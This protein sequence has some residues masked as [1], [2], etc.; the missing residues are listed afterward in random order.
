MHLLKQFV[1][2]AVVALVALLAPAGEPAVT[3]V[4]V[5][6]GLTSPVAAAVPPGDTRRLFIA[7]KTDGSFSVAGTAKVKVLDIVTGTVTDY[8]TVPAVDSTNGEEGVLGI[9]FHP[10]FASNGYFYLNVSTNIGGVNYNQIRR[11]TAT[12]TP[13][14]STSANPGTG[15]VILQFDSLEENHNGGFIGFGAD[16]KLYIATGDGG[17][18]NDNGSGHTAGMGNAQDRSKLLGKILRI[19][20]DA[21]SGGRQYGI[22]AGNP[23]LGNSSGFRE[24]LWHWGL[25]NPFACSFDTNGD[26]WIGDV[27]QGAREEISFA[28]NGISGRNF[29]WRVREGTIATP[30]I[31]GE[32]VVTPATG[33]VVEYDRSSAGGT[34][35]IGG[36]VYRGTA[37]PALA[38]QYFYCDYNSA[39]WW[40]LAFNRSTETVT[41]NTSLTSQ[42][43]GA[44]N[45][46][47]IVTGPD[48]ELYFNRHGTGS[49][50]TIRKII[51]LMAIST[52]SL[53]AGTQGA[54]YSAS[55]ATT[56][57]AGTVTWTLAGGSSLPAGLSL[58]SAGAISGTPSA[59]GTF[60]IAIRATDSQGTTVVR[61]LGLSITAAAGTT[62]T[63]ASPLAPTTAGVAT[64]RTFAATGG[65]GPYTW[66]VTAGSVPSGM[67]LS[68]GGVL[69]GTPASFGAASFTVTATPTAGLAGSKAFTFTVNPTP[70]IT[71]ASL[72]NAPLSGAYSQTLG[73]SGGTPALSWSLASGTLPTGLSLAAGTG[74]ISGTPT[75]A[76]SYPF[77]VRVQDAVG[78][79]ATR[80]LTITVTAA[81]LFTSTPP[82]S[83]A[84]GAAYAYDANATGTPA[85]TYALTAAPAGMTID[86]ASGVITWMPS[87]A[88]SFPVT[89][90]A[91]NG[92]PP[93]A[94]QSF[95]ITATTYG[96]A[97][98]PAAPPYLGMPSSA[99]TARP[100]WLSQTGLFSAVGS[101]TA[102]PALIA[103]SV[104]HPFFSDGGERL[105]WLSV[106]TGSAIQYA[107]TGEWGFPVG[108]VSV[109]HFDL[110]I[111]ERSPQ[112][113]R[114]LETRV[115]VKDQD[116][117]FYGQ[118]YRWT[119]GATDAWRVDAAVTEPIAITGPS[120]AVRSADWYYPSPADCMS[121][122]NANAGTILGI[123]TRQLHRT[124]A[125]PGGGV[126][127]QLRTWAHIGMFANPPAESSLASLAR[128]VAIDAATASVEARA[129]SYLDSNCAGCHRPGGPGLWDGRFDTPLTAQNLINGTINNTLGTADAHEIS[130][131]SLNRSI[132]HRR[133]NSVAAGTRMPPLGRT[134]I[135][136]AGVQLIADWIA[137]I[138]QA[139][140]VAGPADVSLPA[141][142]AVPPLAVAVGDVDAPPGYTVLSAVS[143]NQ[144]LL[145]NAGIAVGGSG[146]ARTLTLTPVAG[147]VGAAVITITATDEGGRT[148]T[149]TVQLTVTGVS[150]GGG[151]RVATLL[152]RIGGPVPA[153]AAAVRVNGQAVTPSGGQ[154]SALVPSASTSATVEFVGADGSVKSRVFQLSRTP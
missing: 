69:S 85:P 52:A 139:P 51:P 111:D 83:A 150:G 47:F 151:S 34:S 115:L 8:M 17:S 96:M 40:R 92:V 114:R 58:S 146:G 60:T 78:A 132:I 56:N 143:S 54:A 129:R 23:Y 12:G 152:Y 24:E 89:V 35:V 109:K 104:I 33:P 16:G 74:L 44:V 77:T 119:S 48:G 88:G 145:P 64:T 79:F 72:P 21:P 55:L 84:V 140:T 138:N 103:Y 120:G 25:R 29:G 110:V 99:F 153:S 116:G 3:H 66:T 67:T 9:C 43:P 26:L 124:H 49:N 22:P 18:S 39:N 86:A 71:T 59:A 81:P 128:L 106:P 135:D 20:V 2:V 37:L 117:V 131:G 28:P 45:A 65:T 82:T 94:S 147:A 76:G 73:A 38:G 46:S 5:A 105:R 98:R 90:V 118:T 130:P 80:A 97:A 19:D 68:T 13:A 149:D 15:V 11:Y 148:A 137:A 63:T 4:Q 136:A 31:T 30:G 87:S 62:V 75:I 41:A 113:R 50:G 122:H 57:A 27:G 102:T 134:T 144:A 121:C 123:K 95:S 107:P 125:F 53:P 6:T 126:D 108:T 61:S 14:T 70:A 36:S 141:G 142:T 10:A 133:M 154:W 93:N 7:E 100:G 91:S 101:L 32:A 1:G 42:L 112:V 127:N